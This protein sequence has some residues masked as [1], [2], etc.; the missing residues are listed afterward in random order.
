MPLLFQF[1]SKENIPV[2][3]DWQIS[4]DA[5]SF[6]QNTFPDLKITDKLNNKDINFALI[7]SNCKPEN[8]ENMNSALWLIDSRFCKEIEKLSIISD[9]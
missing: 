9:N 8:S 3:C 2:V 5:I 7:I 4:S 6:F 1:C